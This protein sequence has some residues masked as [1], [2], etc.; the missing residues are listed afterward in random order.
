MGVPNLGCLVASIGIAPS[1][2]LMPERGL[3]TA[4]YNLVANFPEDAAVVPQQQQLQAASS[5]SNSG[6]IKGGWTREEDEVLRQMVRHHGDRKWAEIAKS[7]P[8]RIGKQCRE[9]WTNHLH[10][11]IKK[12]IWTEEED[13][14]VIRAHQT[15]G[16]RW[17]AIARSLPGRSENTVKNRWNTTSEA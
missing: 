15:Y 12:G 5:N 7:L 16:N 10:P 8:G 13:R 6:L 3:A 4:N 2:S 14:K 1:S 9:R 17:S 11:D